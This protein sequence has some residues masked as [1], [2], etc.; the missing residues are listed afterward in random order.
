MG[1]AVAASSSQLFRIARK[2]DSKNAAIMAT[3]ECLEFLREAITKPT[4]GNQGV[5]I[6]PTT[7]MLATTCVCAGD[8]ET[9]RKH[10]NG[11]LLIVQR[12]K[13]RHSLDPLWWMS[14]RWLVH[15]LLMNR[16]S[17]L[18]LPKQQRRGFIDWDYLLTSMPDLGRIDLGSGLSR[19]LVTALDMVCELSESTYINVEAPSQ[20]KDDI[21]ARKASSL[22]LE[23][24][25]IR[26]RN[27]AAPTVTDPVFRRKLES[28]HRLF[29]DAT[30]LC[31]YRR[32]DEMP[33]DDPKVQTVVNSVIESLE[34]I[35]KES[36]VHA[37][38]L[39]P[40]LTAGCESMTSAQRTIIVER[41]EKMSARGMGSYENVLEFMRHYW[42]HGGHM[43][44][45]LFAKQTGKDL[46]LF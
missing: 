2:P 11:A 8:T 34:K 39:W 41:M 7:L 30:L 29:T 19:E 1:A 31:L 42:K 40:L 38:L 24:R 43:R 17:G 21:T 37:Q 10:L 44:W 45:D 16:L 20:S 36:H 18:P 15:L 13:S 28:T 27:K 23:A 46:V 33:K 6:L 4:F 32:V 12:D 25:L 26:L 14:L 35:D 5:T 3:V 9:F 22:E